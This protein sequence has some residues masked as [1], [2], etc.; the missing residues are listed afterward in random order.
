MTDPAST[1]YRHPRRE[2][3]VLCQRCGKTICGECQ[4][5]AAVGFH[6]P[7]CVKEAKG[8]SRVVQGPRLRRAMRGRVSGTLALLIVIGIVF[9]LQFVTSDAVTNLLGY[10]PPLTAVEPWRLLT[11]AFVHS[12]ITHVILNGY[13]LWVLGTI[14]ERA[15]G[16]ARFLAVF[17]ASTIV[18]AFAVMVLDPATFVVGASAGIFGLFAALFIVNRGFGGSNVSLL[19][20]IGINLALGF[21]IPGIAW[22]AH[23]GGLVGGAI[24]TLALRRTR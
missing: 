17:A 16:T 21:I 9:V 8:Q 13:S 11:Y 22:Q 6:C 7:D 18:G 19:V 4:L 15:L 5:P 1:C 14:I 2:S 10:Y 23:I 20:I 12:G 24:A 3:W